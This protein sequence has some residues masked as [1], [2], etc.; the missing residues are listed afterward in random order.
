MSNICTDGCTV[1]HVN[2]DYLWSQFSKLTLSE[3]EKHWPKKPP[4]NWLAAM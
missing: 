1:H 2:V 4:T 3:F